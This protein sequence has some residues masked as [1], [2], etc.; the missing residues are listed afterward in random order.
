MQTDFDYV[1]P[2]LAVPMPKV[3]RRSVLALSI[4]DAQLS[5]KAYSSWAD[6][7]VLECKKTPGRDWQQDFKLR[8]PAAIAAAARGGADVFVR[9]HS[10]AAAAELEATVFTGIAG[11]VLT[12]VTGP[13]DIKSVAQHLQTLEASRGIASGEL[14][15]DVEVDNAAAV[16]HSLGIARAHERFGVFMLNEPALCLS[17]GMQT[18]PTLDFDPLEYI[19][20]QLITVAT[21]VGSQALGMSYPLGLTQENADEDAVKKA[22]KRA[23]DTGFK[24]AYCPHASWVKLCNEGFRPTAEEAAYYVKVIDVFAEGIKRGMASVPIDGKMI[25]V[26][27]DL[28]AKLYLKWANRAQVRDDE[29][30]AAHQ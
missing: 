15:I 22:I 11:V 1:N 3:I 21:S 16:W 14:E 6:A 10:K 23:R 2:L 12:G 30:S 17:L 25:D 24:G 20:S 13:D 8:V 29:K 27:V 26:P 5:D 18:A 9:V 7:I 28:R 19:K 4:D